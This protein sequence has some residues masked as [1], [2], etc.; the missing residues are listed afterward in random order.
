VVVEGGSRIT[1]A[2]LR[3]ALGLQGDQTIKIYE[4]VANSTGR[5]ADVDEETR[6]KR[7]HHAEVYRGPCDSVLHTVSVDHNGGI[8]PCCGVLPHHDALKV[9]NIL[10]EGVET[11][12]RAA[13]DDPLYRWIKLEGP[14]TIL[15]TVTAT[16]PV[17][18][19]AEDFDGICTAC[20]RIFG[21]PEMLAR[22]RAAAELRR[23]QIETCEMLLD[24]LSKSESLASAR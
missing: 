1:A 6:N 7:A 17:P 3:I 10:E 11:A 12:M 15:A 24:G 16:D 4:T 23:D 5:A 18:M 13:A 20:D 19:R 22:V 2:S 21:S 9:G 8:R 14:V